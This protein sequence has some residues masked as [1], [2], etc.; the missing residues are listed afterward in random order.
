MPAPCPWLE[1]PGRVRHIFTH[2]R[3]ELKI[4]TGEWRGAP[5]VDG[6]WAL[7]EAFSDHALPTVMRKVA[8]HVRQHMKAP[9]A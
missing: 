1:L 6:I 5:S 9:A 3:L 8:A 7:P 2:F 4:Y